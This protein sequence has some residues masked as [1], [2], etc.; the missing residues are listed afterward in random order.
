MI[1]RQALIRLRRSRASLIEAVGAL[2]VCGSVAGLA[3]WLWGLL[4]FGVFLIVAGNAA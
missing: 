4:L 1:L 3:G 2:I